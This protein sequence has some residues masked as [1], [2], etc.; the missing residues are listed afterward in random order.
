MI[1]TTRT[2]I[3]HPVSL[4]VF[5]HHF[6]AYTSLIVVPKILFHIGSLLQQ[7]ILDRLDMTNKK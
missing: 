3:D 7:Y 1:K 6:S 2:M 4:H 5:S